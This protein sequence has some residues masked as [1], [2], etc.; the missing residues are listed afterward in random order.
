MASSRRSPVVIAAFALLVLVTGAGSLLLVWLFKGE[1][2]STADAGNAA[3]VP[4]EEVQAQAPVVAPHHP[5]EL[6]EARAASLRDA[7]S[8]VPVWARTPGVWTTPYPEG[9]KINP[10]LPP[11]KLLPEMVGAPDPSGDA[12]AADGPSP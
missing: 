10:P 9:G 4:T 11:V 1:R 6:P 5:V 12:A 8:D 3:R 2:R 7:G